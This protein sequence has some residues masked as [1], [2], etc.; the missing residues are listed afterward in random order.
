MPLAA[1][2]EAASAGMGAA[3]RRARRVV[4][5]GRLR[6]VGIVCRERVIMLLL[7]LRLRV[8]M[9]GGSLAACAVR[10]ELPLPRPWSAVRRIVSGGDGGGGGGGAAGAVFSVWC[11][12][13]RSIGVTGVVVVGSC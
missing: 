10:R 11:R 13:L 1:T 12:D 5:V 8:I 4:T 7:L 3:A 2:V 9:V 6:A